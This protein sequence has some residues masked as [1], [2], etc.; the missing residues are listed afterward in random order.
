MT[1]IDGP[2][3][4]QGDWNRS[5]P[6]AFCHD[7][8]GKKPDPQRETEVRLLWSD[9]RLFIRF[10]CCYRTVDVFPD[11][12]P[13]GRRHE[14]WDRD[15]AEVFLQP[16]RFGEKF[17]KEF[18]ISPNGM[19]LDLDISPQG[20][21]HLTSGMRSRVTVDE[22]AR[23]WTAELAIPMTALTESFDPAQSWRVNL[24]RCEGLDPQRFYSA[25]RPTETNEPNFHV[26]QKF[27]WLRFAA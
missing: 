20:L 10:Q 4:P 5:E 8:Q 21:R 25:W 27:G 17:Y 7:W 23:I 3:P 15:V 16:D 6:V 26:P 11:A 22:A 19:W 12:D 14:L 2:F 24:F 1:K 9:D 13:N 18:E